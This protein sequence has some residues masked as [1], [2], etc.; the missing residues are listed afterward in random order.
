M[1]RV[2]GLCSAFF[3]ITSVA[4]LTPQTAKK[5]PEKLV[6]KAMLGNVTYDHAKH[7][8]RAK[9]EMMTKY[10]MTEPQAFKWIQRMAMDHRMTMR[11]VADRT[12]LWCSRGPAG[13][14]LRRSRAGCA[15]AAQPE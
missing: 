2:F 4:V 9:G 13:R 8:E 14:F 11:E 15:T 5:P 3:L 6:F 12:C 10:Q 1:R 7:V